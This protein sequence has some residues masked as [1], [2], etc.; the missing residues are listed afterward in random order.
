MTVK[1]Q[2]RQHI[3]DFKDQDNVN[4]ELYDM[5]LL[6]GKRG[7]NKEKGGKRRGKHLG[8]RLLE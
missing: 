6:E 8:W 2:V 3:K 1:Y 7:E 4:E 5:K